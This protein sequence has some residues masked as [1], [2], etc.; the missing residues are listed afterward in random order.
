MDLTKIRTAAANAV[1]SLS[2]AYEITDRE[3]M[4]QAIFDALYEI[5]SV[6]T[7]DIDGFDYLISPY[8][9]I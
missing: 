4:E 8:V 6:D 5:G 7:G 9:E 2:A 1:A 3:G